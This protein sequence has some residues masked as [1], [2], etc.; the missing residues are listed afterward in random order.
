MELNTVKVEISKYDTFLRICEIN[1]LERWLLFNH[2]W[3]HYDVEAK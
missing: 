3:S 1:Y 2:K